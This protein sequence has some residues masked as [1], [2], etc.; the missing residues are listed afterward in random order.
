M[1]PPKSA[2]TCVQCRARKV[3]C[4]GGPHSC[5]NY[6][7]RPARPSHRSPSIGN[8]S[9][10][11]SGVSPSLLQPRQSPSHDVSTDDAHFGSPS[12]VARL[13]VEADA[14]LP[15]S[16]DLPS[17][18]RGSVTELSP[19]EGG[20]GARSIALPPMRDRLQLINDFFRHV[21][22][23]PSYAFL[24]QVSI[25]QRCLDGSLDE[26]RLLA[27]FAISSLHLKYAKY[28]PTLTAQWIQRAEDIIWSKIEK[29]RIFTTQALLLIIHYK[30][31]SGSFQRAYMLMGIAGRTASALR[32]QYVR[33]DFGTLAQ[34]IRRH[35]M[36]CMAL[37]DLSFS[38]GLP[39]SEVCSPDSIYIRLPCSEEDFQTDSDDNDPLSLDGISENGLLATSIRIT[40][41]TRDIIRL[42]RQVRLSSQSMPQLPDLVEEFGRMLEQLEIPPYS[43]QELERFAS[44]KWLARFLTVQLSWHQAHCDA[45]RL[46]LSGYREA[47]PEAIC[48]YHACRLILFLS[49]SNLIPPETNF[50]TEA[51]CHQ[52]SACLK[53]LQRLYKDSSLV[54]FIL[55]DLEAMIQLYAAGDSEHGRDSS[56]REENDTQQ[57]RFAVTVRKHK[58]LG[59]HSVLRRAGFA[60]D[61]GEAGEPCERPQPQSNP[62]PDSG[63]AHGITSEPSV[64]EPVL[65]EGHMALDVLMKAAMLPSSNLEDPHFTFSATNMSTRPPNIIFIMADDHAAKSISCYGAGI[66]KTSNLDRIANEGMRF[67]HCYVTNSICTPSRAAILY[68]THNHVNGVMTLDS[69]INKRLPNV[70][71]QLKS[72]PAAYK[73]AMVG[74]W[75]LGEG[76]DHEPTGFDYWSIV[77]GQGEYWDP[78]FIEPEGTTR[79]PGYATDIITDK[80]IEWMEKR[81]KERP[82]FLMCHHKAPHRSWEYDSKHKDLYKDP[83]RLPDTFT[84]DYKNRANAA[85]VAKMRVAEDLTYTDLR[86]VQQEGPRSQ[87]GEKM[88]DV[89]W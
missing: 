15:P 75:H 14:P 40:L 25:T 77:P 28:H 68:G 87:I 26:T 79:V 39:E 76:N 62:Q 2:S 19:I 66:N 7:K 59:V 27:L 11:S 46:F 31:E 60:D 58:S 9:G 61:S 69:K 81:D 10:A 56:E 35:T 24:N 43:A 1:P 22:P 37:L 36:W 6:G 74:K 4:D 53:L 42:M 80:C 65:D 86:V 8:R 84:D 5:S 48:G 51:A 20:G 30:I 55:R 63:D 47:A 82:F 12:A 78:Q 33:I 89:W 23:L 29:P 71:K 38:I 54:Q 52:A 45:Y 18:W 57:P 85:K 21:H 17:S 83:I 73:T 72:S 50:T 41:I 3:R 34:E 16:A 67:D 64:V 32:L 88:I 49:K 44:S 13:P 70:A